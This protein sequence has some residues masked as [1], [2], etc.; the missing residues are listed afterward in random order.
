MRFAALIT[1]LAITL[2]PILSSAKMEGKFSMNNISGLCSVINGRHLDQIYN[3]MD[4]LIKEGD[5]TKEEFN[6][7]Y[8]FKISCTGRAP[9]QFASSK[10]YEY[11]LKFAEYGVDLKHSFKDI[12]DHITTIKDYAKYQYKHTKGQEKSNWRRIYVYLRKNKIKGCK[13]QP[14]LNCSPKYYKPAS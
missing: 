2:S 13:E 8:I 11:F 7:H 1:A 5:I 14:Q 6:N 4:N 3:K 9:L 10:G 12:D